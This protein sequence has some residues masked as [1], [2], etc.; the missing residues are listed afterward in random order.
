MVSHLWKEG[1]VAK[2]FAVTVPSGA[3]EHRYVIDIPGG[4]EI[5]DEAIILECK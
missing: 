2:S 4:A 5:A 1:G 3:R